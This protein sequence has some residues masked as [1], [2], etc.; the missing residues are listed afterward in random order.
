ML[1][2]TFVVVCVQSVTVYRDRVR[3][4]EREKEVVASIV[5]VVWRSRGARGRGLCA[6]IIVTFSHSYYSAVCG[7]P[8]FFPRL[9]GSPRKH[10]VCPLFHFLITVFC[11]HNRLLGCGRVHRSESIPVKLVSEL[12]LL[13]RYG[14]F[15]GRHVQAHR[16]QMRDMLV[17]KDL[18]L[19]V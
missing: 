16:L 9:L 12:G 5:T 14:R 4:R 18:W 1:L 15:I 2:N 17:V 19:P 3:V 10:S 8:W 7:L 13:K 6:S 11:V